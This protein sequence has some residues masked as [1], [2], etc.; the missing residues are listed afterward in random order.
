V[1]FRSGVPDDLAIEVSLAENLL[2]VS[3]SAAQLLRV[4]SNLLTNACEAM[5]VRGTLL[6]KTE[7]LYVDQP[8]GS[9]SVVEVGEYVRLQ[10]G[11][12]GCG[13][14]LEI[15]GRIFEAFFTTKT[16]GRRR[17]SGLGLS[18]VEAIVADHRGYID[19]ES[20]PGTGS[21]FSVYLP[22]CRETVGEKPAEVYPGGDEAILVVDDDQVQRDVLGNL[23]SSLGYQVR[24]A[25]SGEDALAQLQRQPA[26]LLIVDMIMPAGIDVA[27][28][29]RRAR[30]VHPGLPTIILSGYAESG[31]VRKALTMGVGAYLPKPVT[32]ENLARAVR[33]ELERQ[34][35]G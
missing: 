1:L 22:V 11:D 19:L 34:R 27:E 30:A 28:V 35:H 18:I 6:V 33:H 12:T 9:Y 32:L 31:R 25:A 14:P 24:T 8:I 23:L 4:V 2:P 3:S 7:N 15:R 5:P 20:S 17:G 16:G 10:V 26:D 13:V 21:T 29:Y